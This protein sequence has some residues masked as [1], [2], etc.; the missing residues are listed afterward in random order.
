[1]KGTTIY[2]APTVC[3]IPC[4][5]LNSFNDHQFASTKKFPQIFFGAR[6]QTNRKSKT[7]PKYAIKHDGISE[8]LKTKGE[9]GDQYL[10]LRLSLGSEVKFVAEDN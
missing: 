3:Q 2:C 8:V 5:H 4:K 7:K 1:M 9:K 6:Q 10:E